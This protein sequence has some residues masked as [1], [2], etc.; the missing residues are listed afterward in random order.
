MCA[1]FLSFFLDFLKLSFFL[2]FPSLHSPSSLPLP[3]LLL[4]FLHLLLPLLLSLSL[5]CHADPIILDQEG[6]T[7]R[8][9]DQEVEEWP[10]YLKN[11]HPL[12]VGL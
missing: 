3:F 7:Q 9:E 12:R 8:V 11:M 2:S 5:F 4:L 1:E 10:R 6:R